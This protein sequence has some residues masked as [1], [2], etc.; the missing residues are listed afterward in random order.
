MALQPSS[1]SY[2]MA[3]NSKPIFSRLLKLA[4]LAL[5]YKGLIFSTT[6]ISN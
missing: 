2:Q 6:K 5:F 1:S 3:E 4:V